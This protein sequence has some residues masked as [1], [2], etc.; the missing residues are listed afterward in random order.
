MLLFLSIWPFELCPALVQSV[1]NM[2][3]SGESLKI[4]ARDLGNRVYTKYCVQQKRQNQMVEKLGNIYNTYTKLLAKDTKV[5]TC[6]WPSQHTQDFH[7]SEV[8]TCI[9]LIYFVFAKGNVFSFF[10]FFHAFWSNNWLITT[11]GLFVD[12]DGWNQTFIVVKCSKF[13]IK[14]CC[15]PLF[16]QIIHNW[17]VLKP[18]GSLYRINNNEKCFNLFHQLVEMLFVLFLK[19]NKGLCFLSGVFYPVSLTQCSTSVL[20]VLVHW[21][22][23]LMS[24]RLMRESSL[25]LNS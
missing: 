2:P 20:M 22:K 7:S 6:L 24:L 13:D 25:H 14:F 5:E 17:Q 9:L 4:L 21:E 11:W 3:P 23:T 1:A 18:D 10:N 8:S 12:F 16:R 15:Y 19:W